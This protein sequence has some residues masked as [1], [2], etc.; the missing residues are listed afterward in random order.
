[1]V[2]GN[3]T[4]EHVTVS[5][6]LVVMV[7]FGV[8]VKNQCAF[9]RT[10][11]AGVLGASLENETLAVCCDCGI[12]VSKWASSVREEEK[13]VGV[14]RRVLRSQTLSQHGAMQGSG[15]RG[16]MKNGEG[17]MAPALLLTLAVVVRSVPGSRRPPAPARVAVVATFESYM[18]T[19]QC[20][21][22]LCPPEK[23]V[24]TIAGHLLLIIFAGAGRPC[25]VLGGTCTTVGAKRPCCAEQVEG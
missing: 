14:S 15:R 23:G 1:M 19:M 24:D 3:G 12:Q 5:M 6:G 21:V 17:R 16:R 8:E 10:D 4:H 2:N 18:L 20:G 7:E 13:R 11:R 22:G 25:W 9:S